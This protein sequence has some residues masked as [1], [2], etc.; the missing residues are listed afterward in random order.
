MN[1]IIITVMLLSMILILVT[2]CYRDELEEKNLD[3]SV[4]SN[5]LDNRAS[6]IKGNYYMPDESQTHEG[7]WLQ[8]PHN[9]TYGEGYKESLESIWIEMAKALFLDETVHIVAY[10]EDEVNYIENLLIKENVEMNRV[11]FYTFPTDDVWARDNGPI[12]AFDEK[13]NL[14]ILDWGFNGW[15]EKA[16]YRKDEALR[17]NLGQRLNIE[18]VNLKEVVLEGGAIELDGNGTLMTTRSSVNNM[19]RNPGLT[20]KEIEEYLSE[21]YGVSH[22]IWLDGVEGI[23]ITD[24]HIDGFAKFY[25]KSTILTLDESDLLDW[26][27]IDTDI[28]ILLKAKNIASDN[29]KYIY[30]PLTNENVI[31][32]N[33]KDLGYKGSYINFYV[34]NGVVL[35]PNYNDPNDAIANDIIQ[36]LYPNRRVVGIDIRE[37]YQYGGMIHCVVQQQ[38]V[39]E[40]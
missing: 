15:G 2:G 19:N 40:N 30:I 25:N 22:F 6:I 5:E 24:F 29:Y 35:V 39:S 17:K 20:E 12:F 34:A 31:L 26:G 7:T 32:K 23:D 8:W 9:Y 28:D 13:E 36:G 3:I 33:G 11:N 38:P 1:K 21:I 27:V 37:L 14:K 18:V 10:D 16:P 4:E